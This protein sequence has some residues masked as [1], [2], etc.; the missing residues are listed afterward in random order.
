MFSRSRLGTC[1]PTYLIRRAAQTTQVNVLTVNESVGICNIHGG[2]VTHSYGRWQSK[3]LS[4]TC[5]RN[6]TEETGSGVLTS[7]RASEERSRTTHSTGAEADANDAGARGI[8]RDGGPRSKGN[9]P[10]R[11][12]PPACYTTPIHRERE[13]WHGPRPRTRRRNKRMA[14]L[15]TGNAYDQPFEMWMQV[16]ILSTVAMHDTAEWHDRVP[17][18]LVPGIS[19]KRDAAPEIPVGR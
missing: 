2:H 7:C 1:G 10:K 19:N 13:R 5:F 15:S 9:T 12:P 3:F 6:G 17:T 11:D 18:S 8:Y 16:G 14:V 4:G